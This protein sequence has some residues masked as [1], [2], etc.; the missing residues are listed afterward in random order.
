M[1]RN[2]HGGGGSSSPPSSLF[3]S[4]STSDL[5]R[6]DSGTYEAYMARQSTQSQPD[7]II[8]K[9]GKA[10]RDSPY[11]QLHHQRGLIGVFRIRLLEA[12]DL[13]RSY[14]SAL[15]LGPVKHL[16]F[17]KAHGAVSSYCSFSLEY[18]PSR[19]SAVGGTTMSRR[20][21]DGDRK[22]AA[23]ARPVFKSPVV[24]NDSSPVWENCQFDCPLRKGAMPSDGMRVCLG[25]RVSEDATAL[26][27]FLPGITHG[28]GNSSDARLLGVGRLDLTELCLGETP[29]GQPLPGVC[30]AW[31]PISLRGQELD[32]QRDAA[33]ASA[34]SRYNP[35]DPLAPPPSETAKTK[36]APKPPPV[37]GMVRVLVSYQ[38]C[39]FEPREH[40]LVA[41]ESF[42]RRNPATSS[43]RPI[44]DSPL[45]PLH[46]LERRGSYLLCE[47]SLPDG[48]KACVRL[49]RNAVFV[50]ERTNVV[51]A[52][53]NLALM[54]IDFVS[55]TP[56]GKAVGHALGPV[57]A[58]TRELVMPAMLS[59]KLVWV[60]ART[61]TLAGVSGVQALGGT[62]W[63]E[64]SSSLTA[65][66]RSG[67]VPIYRDEDDRSTHSS[68]GAAVARRRGS[69]N[70]Q[71]VSL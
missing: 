20:S 27:N 24:P 58:A 13:Q 6:A 52:A 37:T 34:N 31:I 26:D 40:D 62:L 17:S 68:S 2:G 54:P 56:V 15:A 5:Y 47:Y 9:Y 66:H 63:H 65:S 35:L 69:A 43:C 10:F 55:Q 45:Q 28:G 33:A 8:W 21:S 67:S 41:L 49:H 16:G 23:Q 71:F 59:L 42:A 57:A 14:W 4:T 51:D 11:R 18:E 46:V 19:K 64:G 3:S 29:S 25:V 22:P 12:S 44:I 70:A 1:G 60:A 32:N 61:T 38:P 30:D 7:K 50:I 53:Q 36:D 48:R 39:G